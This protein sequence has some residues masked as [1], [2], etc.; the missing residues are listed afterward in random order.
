MPDLTTTCG[1]GDVDDDGMPALE[2]VE[3]SSIGEG[4]EDAMPELEDVQIDVD[5]GVVRAEKRSTKPSN[6]SDLLSLHDKKRDAV[7]G[8]DAP[9]PQQSFQPSPGV[10]VGGLPEDYSVDSAYVD[11]DMDS[12]D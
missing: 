6:I 2:D 8:G 12:L 5:K 7:Q 10:V 3:V 9:A 4:Q 1:L 11:T